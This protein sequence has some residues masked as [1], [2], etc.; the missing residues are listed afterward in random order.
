MVNV[1]TGSS[2]TR[3]IK[4][5]YPS[6]TGLVAGTTKQTGRRT[7]LVPYKASKIPER[8]R[9]GLNGKK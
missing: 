4:T 9:R 5:K 3:F 7:G 8:L 1:G 2:G 6:V